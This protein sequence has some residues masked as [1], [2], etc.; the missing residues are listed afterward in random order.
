MEKAYVAD[1]SPRYEFVADEDEAAVMT[2]YMTEIAEQAYDRMAERYGYRPETPIRVEVFA[3][4]ADFSVRTVG[5]TGFGAL[6][7]SFGNVLAINSPSAHQPGHF[8]WGSTLW[9]EIS[10]TF[11]LGTT[12]HMIPRWFT[13]GLAVYDE[14]LARPGWGNDV[15][16]DFLLA[17]L[18]GELLPIADLNR[19]FVRPS[20]P[21]QIGHVYYHSSLVCE[22]I[23]HTYG[24][25]TILDM[26]GSYRD[27]RTTPEVVLD[28]LG[29]STDAFD[30]VFFA[31]FEERFAG[32]IAALSEPATATQGPP[33]PGEEHPPVRGEFG[34]EM[35]RAVEFMQDGR[36]EEA[37]AHLEQAR[38]LFPEYAGE[39]APGVVL[40]ELY[41]QRGD[42]DAAIREL[43]AVT[44]INES[45]LGAYRKLADLYGETGD[46]RREA[47][48]L[49]RSMYIWPLDAEAHVR[50]A[51]LATGLRDSDVEIQERQAIVALGPVDMAE[52]HYRLA[53]AYENAGELRAARSA[54]LAALEVAPNF[55]DAQDLLLRLRAQSTGGGT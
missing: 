4:H 34:K 18:D 52:A 49:E 39:D 1:A 5:V 43:A 8:N 16:L 31:W 17:W 41:E 6:G 54:V 20:Y 44:D 22:M 19:G 36:S 26:L 7:V 32:P 27:G 10:H 2:L 29:M 35:V 28:V 9:H 51:E 48:I 21:G 37:I 47:D 50:L 12:N 45:F 46:A 42:L 30:E 24:H 25:Q 38:D 11:T 55:R 14:R 13:E 40:A 33:A 23:E 15:T 3:R 53:L